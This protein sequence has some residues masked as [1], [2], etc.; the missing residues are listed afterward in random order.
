MS[1]SIGVNFIFNIINSVSSLLFPLIAFSYASRIIMADG[2]G[3]V[4]FFQ[5]IINY[6]ILLTS[7][8]IP[9]YGIREIARVRDDRYDLSKTTIEIILLNFLLNVIGYIIVVIMCFTVLSIKDNLSLFLVL[10]SSIILTTIGCPWFYSG[11]EDFK[12]I[13]IVGVVVKS[14]CL[15]FLFFFVRDKG[16]VLYYG[17]YTILGSIGNYIINFA[18]LKKYIYV[19]VELIK[20][21]NVFRHAKPA[22]A[23]FLFNVVTSIY[24]NL[25]S[26]MLGFLKNSISVGY[27]TAATKVSHLLVTVITSFGAVLLPRSSNLV[28]QN[29]FDEFYSLSKKSYD[30]IMMVSFPLFVGVLVCAPNLIHLFCGNSFEPAI[31]TL[32]I[33]SPII[34]ALGIS[35]LIGIQLLYP[36]GKIKLVT[37]STCIGALVNISLNFILIPIY[38]QNGAAIA[39]L[40]AEFSVTFTQIYLARNILPF[41]IMDSHVCKYVLSSLVVLLLC[42]FTNMIFV[43]DLA[44]LLFTCIIGIFVYCSLMLLFKDALFMNMYVRCFKK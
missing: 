2:I 41:K 10:S 19:D 26:V 34:I 37:I 27:Y 21:L 38:C 24:I 29:R 31:Y 36:L 42:Y 33:I 30:L 40:F 18:R 44:S 6:I 9:L 1:K 4:Q 39:T 7:L 32:R 3:E 23:I 20:D 35:N 28:K 5:S 12:Y 14:S 8:G 43:N 25:D 15:V 16:D 17:V 22:F 11:L 13:T